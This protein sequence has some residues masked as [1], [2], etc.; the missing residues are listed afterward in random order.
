VLTLNYGAYFNYLSSSN[1]KSHIVE[2]A[3]PVV[4]ITSLKTG[5]V[6]EEGETS[7]IITYR[8]GTIAGVSFFDGQ[9]LLGVE[10]SAPYAFT[11]SNAS[12]GVNSITSKAQAN[13]LSRCAS[14]SPVMNRI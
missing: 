4:S 10:I 12:L 9:A 2:N 13:D 11:L 8:N 1:S 5:Y 7:T 3:A 6:I 14:I